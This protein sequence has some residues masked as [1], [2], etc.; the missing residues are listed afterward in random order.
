MRAHERGSW[1][2]R[3]YRYSIHIELLSLC[4]TFGNSGR[5]VYC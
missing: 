1:R 3:I 2:E 5:Q 4:G